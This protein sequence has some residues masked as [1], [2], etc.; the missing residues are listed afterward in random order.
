MLS[1]LQLSR[2]DKLTADH[3]IKDVITMILVLFLIDIIVSLYAIYCMSIC[4][5]R[6]KIPV[7]LAIVLGILIFSPGLGFMISIGIIAYHFAMCGNK[8]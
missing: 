3:D 4:V 5:R 8:T 7:W 6:G 2:M 1:S